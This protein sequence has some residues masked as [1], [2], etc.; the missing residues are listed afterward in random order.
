MS[1]GIYDDDLVAHVQRYPGTNP[2]AEMR[3]IPVQPGPAGHATVKMSDA[4]DIQ[5]DFAQ[6][7]VL[8]G[9]T[10]MAA[11]DTQAEPTLDESDIGI[12][13][14]LIG[15]DRAEQ[16]LQAMASSGDRPVRIMSSS[17][18]R[19][20]TSLPT[21]ATSEGRRLGRAGALVDIA[22]DDRE[23]VVVRAVAALEAAVTAGEMK[24]RRVVTAVMSEA[25]SA[26]IDL[27]EED[28]RTPD[29]LV[30]LRDDIR[31]LADRD[32]KIAF[33]V[34]DVIDAA[35]PLLAGRAAGVAA[36]VREVLTEAGDM[37]DDTSLDQL[38][39]SWRTSHGHQVSPAF[40]LRSMDYEQ[41]PAKTHRPRMGRWQKM[42]TENPGGS[43]VR[44]LDP[45]DQMLIGLVPVRQ[46]KLVWEAEAIVPT[47][48]PIQEWLIE[49]TDMP[50]PPKGTMSVR[51][52]LDAIQLGRI[53]AMRTAVAGRR[54]TISSE[55]WIACAEAWKAAGDREREARA[56]EYA[57][58]ARVDR[59]VFLADRV[60]R[61]LGLES[62]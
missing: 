25:E 2:Y 53:A 44:I 8:T 21:R 35:Q 22:N 47:T 45:D 30:S 13:R 48:R 33:M 27:E 36:Y 39:D 9:I 14:E 43:W 57:S 56:R 3:L 15:D 49:V 7:S 19:R 61:T 17:E 42:W 23:T 32:P 50:L 55:A 5:V 16:V 54:G 40:M 24:S 34:R 4:I 11:S 29:D 46:N 28:A 31:E 41:R 10:I 6:V 58:E 18:R 62:H 59:P 51:H 20:M 26:L 52:I 60:R 38:V 1:A 12:L 37:W